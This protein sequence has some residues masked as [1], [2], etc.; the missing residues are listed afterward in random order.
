MPHPGGGQAKIINL[1]HH[2]GSCNAGVYIRKIP[3]IEGPDPGFFRAIPYHQKSIRTKGTGGNL[4]QLL[5]CLC[6][7]QPE[8]FERL[9]IDSSGSL[10]CSFYD[11]HDQIRFNLPV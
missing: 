5:F 2:M 6:G 7:T 10:I 11:L 1:Q 9:L 3:V 8:N 4:L